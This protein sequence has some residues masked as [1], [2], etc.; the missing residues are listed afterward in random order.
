MLFAY[1]DLINMAAK[2]LQTVKSHH[3]AERCTKAVQLPPFPKMV[4][5][6]AQNYRFCP[7]TKRLPT[8]TVVAL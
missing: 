2:D 1:E 7:I 5:Q 3:L 4:N 6:A 8:T